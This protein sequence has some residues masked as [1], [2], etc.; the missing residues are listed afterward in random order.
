MS[1]IN[2]QLAETAS[3]RKQVVHDLEDIESIT[4]LRCIPPGRL[5]R[6]FLSSF[7]PHENSPCSLKTRRLDL[8]PCSNSS[9]IDA[10]KD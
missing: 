10:F 3:S 8:K 6:F 1:M 7:L 5:A 4:P 9:E 2:L